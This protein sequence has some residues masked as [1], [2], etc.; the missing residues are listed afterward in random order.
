MALSFYRQEELSSF[1]SLGSNPSTC[2]T[3]TNLSQSVELALAPLIEELISYNPS[4]ERASREERGNKPVSLLLQSLELSVS[5]LVQAAETIAY[6]NDSKSQR[7]MLSAVHR[8]KASAKRL[9]QLVARSPGCVPNETWQE[10]M[11]VREGARLLMYDV[12]SVLSVADKMDVRKLVEVAH[13]VDSC[14]ESLRDVVCVKELYQQI[15]QFTPVM[16]KL[17]KLA[18]QRQD[19]LGMLIQFSTMKTSIYTRSVLDCSNKNSCL[20]ESL[21]WYRRALRVGCALLISSCKCYVRHPD[22]ETARNNRDFSFDLILHATN[23]ISRV[24]AI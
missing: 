12:V 1:G 18:L 16:A 22:L 21:S 23:I 8:L 19:E 3:R 11:S 2:S 13:S 10:Q 17:V 4:K 14:I 6:E 20:V 15:S 7:R 5:R 24:C 9:K